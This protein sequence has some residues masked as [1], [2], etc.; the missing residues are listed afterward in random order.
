MAWDAA[1]K[2]TKVKLQ[3]LS[4][5]DMYLFVEKG[6][7]GGISTIT[8]RLATANNPKVSGYNPHQKLVHLLYIDA[9]NLYGK[10]SSQLFSSQLFSS[11]LFSSQIYSCLVVQLFSSSVASSS[12][13]SSSVAS[14]SV[15][16]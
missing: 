13:A 10:F 2:F 16:Q 7:R 3:L 5:E 11:Q 14:C 9:N 15:V 1:L 12:V 4:R 8:K 6:I